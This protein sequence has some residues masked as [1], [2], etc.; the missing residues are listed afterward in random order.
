MLID[1]DTI[2]EFLGIEVD[3]YDS[4]LTAQEEIISQSVEGYCGRKFL[5]ASYV[6]TFYAEDYPGQCKD[7]PTFHYPILTVSSI[8]R[9]TVDISEDVRVH[10][11][12][13]NLHNRKGFFYHKFNEQLVV[14]YTAGLEELPAPVS[15]VILS[16]IEERY[17][18]KKNGVSLNFGSDV[19]SISIPGTISIAFDY[20]LQANERKTAY[21]TILGNFINVL[22]AYRSERVIVGSGKL[23]YVEA[24]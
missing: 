14:E 17:N 18:K 24:E 19:Q 12:T 9:D 11:E 2:K 22:D 20:S 7:L 6:Q 15:S 4:F 23:A 3:T 8:E 5:E 1:L 10:K 16:L 13:G 21:G